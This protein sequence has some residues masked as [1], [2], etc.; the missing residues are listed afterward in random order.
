MLDPMADENQNAE[1]ADGADVDLGDEFE[2][3]GGGKKSKKKLILM[4]V[5]LLLVL[6]GAGLFFSGMLNSL[7]GKDAELEAE[8]EEEVEEK[9]AAVYYELPQMLV[10][11]NSPGRRS[12]FLKIVVSLE[13]SDSEDIAGLKSPCRG[14]STTFRSICVSCGWRICRGPPESTVCVRSCCSA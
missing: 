14:S 13:L 5:P 3:E 8:V 9:Q 10:N 12:N 7:L 4:A 6:I 1:D 2:D 11:L